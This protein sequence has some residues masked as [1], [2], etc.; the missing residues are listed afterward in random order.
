M[1][2]YRPGF[3]LGDS[4]TGR[5]NPDDFVARMICGCIQLGARPRL[6]RQ[7]KEFV[8]V[9]Y[10]SQALLHIATRKGATGTAYHLVPP[11]P[12]QSPDLDAFFDLLDACGYPLEALSY[13]GWVERLSHEARVADNAL[14][15]LIPMLGE[16]V[17]GQGAT[18]W[19][20]Y[21]GMPVYDTRNTNAALEGTGHRF[22][23]MDKDLLRR[24]LVRWFQAG[25]LPPPG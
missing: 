8:P 5:G 4:Q 16:A 17:Y 21:E 23:A 15:P 13:G 7:R 2:V 22:H 12:E 14:G 1:N 3:V 18:R 6:P 9:D 20:L 10:V 24:Y 19:E 25:L 11:T